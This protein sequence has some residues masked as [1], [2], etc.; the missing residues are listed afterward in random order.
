MVV[1]VYYQ[2]LSFYDVDYEVF[3][4]LVL[5]GVE[6]NEVDGEG[7][8]PLNIAI[9]F[10]RVDLIELFLENG[11]DPNIFD[12][13]NYNA[14]MEE[15]NYFEPDPKVVEMLLDAGA[16]PNLYNEQGKTA[17]MLAADMNNDI[18]VIKLLLTRVP[19]LK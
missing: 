11:A 2:M 1:I 17:L 14:L 19:I 5:A 10:A 16:D 13:Y 3:E 6:L 8:L 9:Y 7:G 4:E 15:V 12:D 18:E